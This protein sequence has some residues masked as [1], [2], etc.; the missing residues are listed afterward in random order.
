MNVKQPIL[1]FA[2]LG[3]AVAC[4]AAP[5]VKDDP[6]VRDYTAADIPAEGLDIRAG[7]ARF[8]CA[9]GLPVTARYVRFTVSAS[10]PAPAQP[11][12]YGGSGHQISEFLLYDKGQPVPF[13]QGT[14]ATARVPGD[15][16]REGA[17][18]CVDGSVDTK[19]YSGYGIPLVIDFG[20]FVT[21]D[22]YG[23]VTGNDAP[24]RDPRDWTLEA[25]VAT[26]KGIGWMRVGEVKGFEA[27]R[28]RKAEL[29][30]TFP[31]VLQEVIPPFAAV[32]VGP[33]GRLVLCGANETLE[34]LS[35][36]GIVEVLPG[37]RLTVLDD[38][39]F[40]GTVIGGGDVVFVRPPLF[41]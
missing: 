40:T 35:G 9:K 32:N 21:F 11:P 5:L 26:E 29:G 30:V 16:G 15:G 25:G 24:G 41:P 37:A 34:R 22:A 36:S 12:E 6:G 14:R 28:A 2:A 39:S 4:G 7:T 8:V 13:P 1:G 27:T 38:G 23:W 18:K 3:V 17:P 33:K 31:A 10:R 20:R 19:W